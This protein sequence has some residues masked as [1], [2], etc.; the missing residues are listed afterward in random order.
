MNKNSLTKNRL[1][2]RARIIYIGIP[3]FAIFVLLIFGN[4]IFTAI[5]DDF[6]IRLA[7]QYSIEAASNFQISS[8]EHF[9]LMQQ[10]SRSV[11]ISRWLANEN[12]EEIQNRAFEEIMGYA[13]F[14]PYIYLMFTVYE[15]LQGYDFNVNLTPHE[16]VPWGTLA[17]GDVSQW[18]F[19]TRD[20][21]APFILN[22]QRTRPVDGEYYIYVWSNH[23]MYYKQQFVGVVTVGSR[24]ENIFENVFG[25]FD[26]DNMRGY[27]IDRHGN[28]RVDSAQI[29]EVFAVGLPTFPSIPEI[30]YNP[31]L[32]NAVAYH[33]QLM[34]DG[35]FQPGGYIYDAIP[36]D[37]G[38]YGHGS[39]A[40]IIGTDWSV[41]VLSNHVAA[42]HWHYVPMIASAFIIL[43]IAV[44]VGSM[45]VRHYVLIP[46]YNLT[47]SV[48]TASDLNANDTIYGVERDDEIGELAYT[49]FSMRKRLKNAMDD[50][51]RIEIAEDGNRSKSQFLARMSHEIRTP[52]SVV[53]GIAEIQLQKQNHLP[54]TE[55]A[56]SKIYSSSTSLLGIINDILDLSRIESGKMVLYNNKYSS[57]SMVSDI[58]HTHLSLMDDD[59][60]FVLNID[61]NLPASLIGDVVRIE[62]VVNNV[63]SNAFKYTK[64]GT[65]NLSL[66]YEKS[67]AALVISVKDTGSGMTDKQLS[68]L[69]NEYARFH[70]NKENY[71]VGAGLGMPIVLNLVRLMNATIDIKSEVNIGTLVTIKIPQEIVGEELLDKETINHLQNFKSTLNNTSKQYDFK[72][73]P[74]PYGKVL[75]VDDIDANLYVAK[76]LLD[77]YKLN[78]E[79]CKNAQEAIFK[80]S[81]GNVYDIIFMDQMMPGMNGTQAMKTLR[82]MG[83]T[84]PIIVLTA[85]TFMGQTEEFVKKGFDGFISK[86][87]KSKH[88][89]AV[90]TKFVKNKQQP[91]DLTEMDDFQESDEFLLQLRSDFSTQ[92]FDIVSNIKQAIENGEKEPAKRLTHTLKGLA[93]LIKESNLQEIAQDLEDTL[94]NNDSI[95]DEQI[96]ALENEFTATLKNIEVLENNHI[97]P[98]QKLDKNNTSELFG[99]LIPLL[100]KRDTTCMAFL[101]ELRTLS[102]TEELISQMEQ[103]EFAKA[104]KIAEELVQK[105]G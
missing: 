31:A 60:N 91:K 84:H 104:Q 73:E 83:Y 64:R 21:E 46:L 4:Y 58:I 86:P 71:I 38:I 96:S 33:L 35:V 90:I 88:L 99:K 79:T 18:F 57:A 6:A 98:V 51:K 77:F 85:N 30:E 11:S 48:I 69:Y 32:Y 2:S 74:M 66:N 17:G 44:V 22:I 52:I 7:R 10:I 72:P 50:A 37:S 23:R 59:I 62:Q 28:V 24:F 93:G 65:V 76:G 9:V 94:I 81:N 67:D 82:K 27:I 103:F 95:T 42:F 16:F 8:N 68:I 97:S 80:V 29:V 87:I 40:P 34:T 36:L 39:I 78:I 105:Y 47:E 26:V 102:E 70:E 45:T 54:E 56:F 14:S 15:S 43:L 5:A 63:L 41:I 100:A 61:E 89:N 53:L 92:H 101:P 25:N 3:V 75:V 1:A 19:D 20:A 49:I 55:E 12:N 13:V